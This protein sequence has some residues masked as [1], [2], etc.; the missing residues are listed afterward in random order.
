MEILWGPDGSTCDRIL[1]VLK[2]V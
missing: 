1:D 2:T